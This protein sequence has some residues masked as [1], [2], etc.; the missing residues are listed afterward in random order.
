MLLAAVAGT[1]GAGPIIIPNASFES[2]TTM[3]VNT[4]IDSWQKPPKPDWYVES[5]GYT[6]DQ[7]AG[8]FTNTPV[9]SFDHID[10]LDGGQAAYM[11]AIPE[12]GLFQDYDSTDWS[13]TVPTHAF[14]ALYTVGRSYQLTVGVIGGGGNMMPGATLQLS[15]Y[16]RD[17]ASNLVTVAAISISNTPA[18]F[19]N[20]THMVDFQVT[21]PAVKTSDAWA[22]RHIGVSLLSTVSTNLEGGYWDLDNVRLRE[23]RRLA[24]A[25]PAWTNGRFSFTLESDPG[26]RF[27][28]LA[29]TNLLTPLAAWATLA[30]VTNVTGSVVFTDSAATPAR[31][32]YQARQLP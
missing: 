6:W 17:L 2:P 9:T 29:G 1:A 21:T 11:F 4:H 25:G 15:L 5:G 24:L 18:V 13:N 10:N 23:S 32:F 27:Q 12:V 30:T 31:R 16:Y 8:L 3:F 20:T 19:S 28:I 22:N 7:L 26:L 14:N